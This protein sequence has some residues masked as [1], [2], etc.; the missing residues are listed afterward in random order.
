LLVVLWDGRVTPCCADYDGQLIVGK[1][2]EQNLQEIFNGP[3]MRVLR[4]QHLKKQWSG[5]CGQ[6]SFYEADYHLSLRKIREL[7]KEM[8]NK[9]KNCRAIEKRSA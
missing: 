4:K 6:C 8:E 1:A 3:E 9:K 2:D 7:R 5:L